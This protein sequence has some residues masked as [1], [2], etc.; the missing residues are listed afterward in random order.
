MNKWRLHILF[1]NIIRGIEIILS[2]ILTLFIIK[3]ICNLIVLVGLI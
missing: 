3:I 1:I 2:F